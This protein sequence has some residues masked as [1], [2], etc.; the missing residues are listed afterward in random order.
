MKTYIWYAAIPPGLEAVVKREMTI[1][2][3]EVQTKHGAVCFT[4]TI[5]D[6][7]ALVPELFTPNKIRVLLK[8]TRISGL[9]DINRAISAFDWESVLHR[10]TPIVVDVQSSRSK[11]YRK[12]IIRSKAE[13]CFRAVLGTPSSDKIPQ[14]VFLYIE[15]NT[16][17]IYLD[18]GGGLLHKRGWRTEQRKAPLRETYASALLLAAGWTPEETLLDPLCGSGTIPIEACRMAYGAT[19]KIHRYPVQEWKGCEHITVRNGRKINTNIMGSDRHSASIALAQSHAES[20]DLSVSWTENDIADLKLPKSS[21]L[22][23]TNPPYGVR[24]G[25]NVHN[26]YR[27]LGLLHKHSP[28]WRMIFLTPSRKLARLVSPDAVHL[29]RFSNGGIDVGIWIV[30]SK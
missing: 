8:K 30:H 27:H 6:G 21:G 10:Q 25:N 26:V 29:T 20:L 28:Q 23:A 19:A 9:S 2:G 4:A 16:L 12:D 5:K 17:Y 11:W 3:V 7:A 18:A 24:L 1:E 15:R 14:H 13:R 22:I